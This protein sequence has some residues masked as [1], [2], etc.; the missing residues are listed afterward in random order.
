MVTGWRTWKNQYNAAE[1][2]LFRTKIVVSFAM[3][4]ISLLLSLWRMLHFV[5]FLYGVFADPQ[6]YNF[7]GCVVRYKWRMYC[8]GQYAWTQDAV[9]P[10]SKMATQN[11]TTHHSWLKA[12]LAELEKE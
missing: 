2:N 1:I 11:L 12:Q 4:A 3:L 7:Q 10:Y 9:Y 8:G 5:E 6:L